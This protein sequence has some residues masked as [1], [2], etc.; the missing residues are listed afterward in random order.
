LLGGVPS[1]ACAPCV[2]E[3]HPRDVQGR[4]L[5]VEQCASGLN[6]AGLCDSGV[7]SSPI[8]PRRAPSRPARRRRPARRARG[9]PDRARCQ[10]HPEPFSQRARMTAS[11]PRWIA[12][13]SACPNA[14]FALYSATRSASSRENAYGTPGRGSAGAVDVHARAARASQRVRRLG[15]VWSSAANRPA[16]RVAPVVDAQ[17]G[18]RASLRV[19]RPA[20]AQIRVVRNDN[21]VSPGRSNRVALHIIQTVSPYT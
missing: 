20:V 11:A 18:L 10:R 2:R 5:L 16:V 15:V 9:E 6:L 7:L 21:L 4:G 3:A 12:E 13:S 1:S 19:Q 17:G 8:V 14:T